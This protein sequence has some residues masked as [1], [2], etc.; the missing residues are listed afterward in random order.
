MFIL[1][2]KFI[3]EGSIMPQAKPLLTSLDHLVLTVTDIGITLQFYEEV[4]GM[5]AETF[6]T[7]TG[8]TRQAL[9]FGHSKINLHQAGAEFE[10]K[11]AQATVGSGDLCFLSGTPLAVWQ[12]HLLRSNIQIEDGPV[13]RTGATG[14]L[15][16]VYIRDPDG[17]L[18]E[19]AVKSS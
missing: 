4:L 8:E 15:L 1:H 7:A 6:T 12:E 14:P 13:R 11:A 10:P 19:I 16:S 3:A 5:T 18:I 17:N 2:G 9:K